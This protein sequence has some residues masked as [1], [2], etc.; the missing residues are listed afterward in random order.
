MAACMG[1]IKASSLRAL[2][3]Q[4]DYEDYYVAK[5]LEAANISLNNNENYI[6]RKDAGEIYYNG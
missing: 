1:Y 6:I 3:L 2:K 4:E 5:Y